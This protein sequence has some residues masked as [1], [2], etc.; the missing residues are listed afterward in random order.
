MYLPFLATTLAILPAGALNVIDLSS[1]PWALSN[2]DRNISVPGNV[3]SSV[4]LDL[5][6]AQVIPDPYHGLNEIDLRWVPL[7]R[8]NYTAQ[9]PTT[10]S[11]SADEGLKTYLLFN[12]LDTFADVRLC[13]QLVA[14]TDNQFRQYFFDVTD[15]LQSP[16]CQQQQQQSG[17]AELQIEFASAPTVAEA[18]QNQPGQETW[19]PYVGTVMEFSGRQFIRK[20]HSDFGWDWG[21]AF[22]PVGIWQKAWVVQLA[23]EEEE[24]YV[25]NSVFDLYREGQLNNL[26]P[27]QG[28]HWVLN[29]SVDV[30]GVMPEGATM[31]YRIVDAATQREVSSGAL[32]GI[33][34]DG[35]VI[36]GSV[37][38][39]K[40]DYAL[41]WP[42]G[43]GPQPLYNITVDIVSPSG[44]TLSSV[45]K[46]TGFRTIVLNTN[47]VTDEEI[48][49]GVAPGNHYHF[50]VNGHTFYVKGSNFIPPDAFWTRVTPT[51]IRQLFDAV[52]AGNQNMLRIWASGVYA[53]DYLYDIADELGI[54]LWSE[55]QFG[56]ALYPV[57]PDFLENVRMEAVYNVRRV[58]HHPS[59]ALWAGGNELESLELRIVRYFAPGEYARYLAEYEALFLET[60]VPA[61]FGNSRS[62][63]YTPSS[64]SNGTL[65][66][67]FGRPIPIAQRYDDLAPGSVYGNTEYYNYSAAQA[68]NLANYPVGRL[69]NEFGFHSMPSL[70]SWRRVL[71]DA[72]LHFNSTPIVQRNH[73]NPPSGLDPSNTAPSLQGMGEMTLAA[74]A[75]YPVP[76]KKTAS[77]SSS[78]ANFSAWCHTTQ[79][80][81][82]DF[83]K[84][85]IQFYRAGSS[86]PERQLGTLYWQLEDTWQAP[87]WA[88]IEYEGR[89]KVL[90]HVARD[91]Y[92]PVIVA[93]LWDAAAGTLR[94][95]AVSDLWGEV[96][97]SMSFGWAGW[98]GGVVSLGGGGG[99]GVQGEVEFTVGAVNATLVAELSIA[100]LR[101]NPDFRAEDV[102]FVANLTASG[103]PPN[104]QATRTYTHT[105]WA[106]P[107]PLSSAALVDPGLRV[108]Y[109]SSA[110]EFVVR[111]ETGT[112]M[113]TWVHVH[114]DD[115]D[116][117]LVNFH[118]NGFLLRKG[119][120]RR[121][122]YDRINGDGGDETW[123]ERVGV[124]S[125]WDNTLP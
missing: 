44:T 91:V 19:P 98:D 115:A 99:G 121:F 43:L 86:R 89:W 84:S 87:T 42:N 74:Q 88:G 60:L 13:A 28:A 61:V 35:D 73:H 53:P 70:A 123:K 118:E 7:S 8:W 55:F 23:E 57:A 69:I 2:T 63:S 1:T 32:T 37:V 75:F 15:I 93:P 108:E 6:A 112:S 26:P 124:S 72:D 45:T 38:L 54:L 67:D 65:S 33:K 111:A 92:A 66:I 95:Y 29:A 110:D 50:E 83:Y 77:S 52:V 109:D 78:A 100:E 76:D 113:W 27:D 120:E 116:G 31:K 4:H 71:D 62:V 40:D 20:A 56:D 3:P 30:I 97:G 36:T 46:R 114:E 96:K 68:F 82:A 34:N 18:I 16:A 24:V 58:N 107:T 80:F 119:E 39:S 10:I 21:P 14:S 81:Q 64:T 48:S 12:G 41:W 79:I 51:K 103:V 105:N 59:L 125:I 17:S 9:L 106:T 117:V 5:F 85:Q 47:V 102:V 11:T 90:H 25:R 94:V 101:A 22:S 122:G 104:E 49:Q